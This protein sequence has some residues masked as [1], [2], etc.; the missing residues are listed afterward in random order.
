MSKAC[1]VSFRHVPCLVAAL[2][3][4]CRSIPVELPVPKHAPQH[5]RRYFCRFGSRRGWKCL[6][7]ARRE[8][9]RY[10]K[11][12]PHLQHLKG[13]TVFT[14]SQLLCRPILVWL[15]SHV[16]SLSCL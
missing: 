16:M 4:V 13:N 10:M 7:T 5:G 8:A 2:I 12:M 3:D 14:T 15:L 9:A 1:I 6:Q 11:Y